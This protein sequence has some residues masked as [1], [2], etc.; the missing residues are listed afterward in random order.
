MPKSLTK[1]NLFL[2][3][4]FVFSRISSENH[5]MKHIPESFKI[6][7]DSGLYSRA[8][9]PLI[10]LLGASLL[11]ACG[12]VKNSSSSDAAQ[13]GF[14]NQGGAAFKNAFPILA[15]HCLAC[16]SWSQWNESD[17]LTEGYIIAN[18]PAQS[19]IYYRI[20]NNDSG[21]N[22]GDMPSNSDSLSTSELSLI[23]TWVQQASY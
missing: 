21:T 10:L 17:F 3:Q 8:C 4:E 18:S 6:F 20:K 22:S 19:M 13:F 9:R 15:K 1:K 5:G 7:S 2:K 16:H 23:K 11:I 12:K 14:T